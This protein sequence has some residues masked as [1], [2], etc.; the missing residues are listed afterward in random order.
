MRRRLPLALALFASIA[1][2]RGSTTSP[3]D[4]DPG[5]SRVDDAHALPAF[6]PDE[7]AAGVG[8]AGIERYYVPLTDAPTRG[9]D[10]A[11]VTV[12]MFSDFECPFCERGHDI[13]LQ[14]QRRYPDQVRIAYK[15]FPLDMH[16]HA[17]LAAMAARSAQAQ[18]KFWDFHDRLFSRGGL[19]FDTILRHASAAQLDLE[20]LR[21]DLKALEYGPEVGRDLRLGKRLGVH[22]TPTFFINGRMLTGAQPMEAFEEV[23]DDE[24][25]RVARWR[26]EG[27]ADDATYAHAIADGYRKVVFTDSDQSLDPDR[28]VPVPLGSSPRR[29]SD[30]APVTIVVFGDFECPFCA[31]G[32]EVMEELRKH[33]GND[34]RLVYKHAPLSFHSH[35]YVASRAAVAAHAQGKFWEFH[36]ALYAR[37]AR[38]DSDDLQEIA[39]SVGLN[40]KTFRRSMDSLELDAAI[41]ADQAL[42]MSL[43]VSGTPA[44]FVNGRPV[45]GAQPELVFRL[46]I[47]EELER[48]RAATE[49]GVAG[50][51]LYQTLTHTPL[52]DMPET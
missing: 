51:E 28:V 16:P 50:E 37:R 33:Y 10:D 6:T 40:M 30:A 25:R 39:R 48:A 46:L 14:L 47:E 11:A 24:L 9:P 32:H 18:G 3:D 20:A 15:A 29:G 1:C 13:L 43:G 49:R 23:V 21:D 19:D 12:V 7:P 22:S 42:A 31:R 35:A 34:L 4:V 2:Q 5:V 17:L 26:Q 38:F 52:D 45:N 8:Q 41:E 36:D 44:F 27:V